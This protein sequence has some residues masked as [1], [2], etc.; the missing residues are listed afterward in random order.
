MYWL[1][2]IR[3]IQW[4]HKYCKE[5]EGMNAP[6]GVVLKRLYRPATPDGPWGWPVK[7]KLSGLEIVCFWTLLKE[8][9]IVRIRNCQKWV[10]SDILKVPN[11]KLR[12]MISVKLLFKVAR[13]RRYSTL[14]SHSNSFILDRH[15]PNRF[16]QSD[17]IRKCKEYYMIKRHKALNS[18]FPSVSHVCL[19][20]KLHGTSPS[21]VMN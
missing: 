16:W 8:V 19:K 18:S 1:I 3:P 21:S 20:G 14:F 4:W 2:D 5:Q 13:S 6:K 10:I 7:R 17:N 12:I 9:A 11:K 15:C